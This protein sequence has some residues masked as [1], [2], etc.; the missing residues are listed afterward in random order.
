MGNAG[1]L[2][3]T[4]GMSLSGSGATLDL[5]TFNLTVP[6]LSGVSGTIVTS[7]GG[8]TLTTGGDNSNQTFG[9][10]IQSSLAVDKQGSGIWTLAGAN[11]YTGATTVS[12]GTLAVTGSLGGGGSLT[13]AL[14]ATLQGT[15]TITKACV[16][17]GD[18]SPGSSIGTI[19]LVGNQVFATGSTLNIELNPTMSDRVNVTGALTIQSGVTLNIIPDFGVYQA[20]LAYLIIDTT[21]GIT[22][23]FSTVT[24]SLPLFNIDNIV[25]TMD[26]ILIVLSGGFMPFADIITTG[27]ANQAAQAL[28]SLSA[29]SCCDISMVIATLR[30]IPTTHALKEALLQLQ[31]AL[32]TD[33][34]LA[35]EDNTHYVQNTI[36]HRLDDKTRSPCAST[37]SLTVWATLLGG[38]TSQHG[39]DSS[40]GFVANTPGVFVGI[41]SRLGQFS[42]VGC[43]V[44]YTYTSLNWRDIPRS[45][46]N[47][48]SRYAACYGK[49]ATSRL[50]VYSTLLGGYT[51][52]SAHRKMRFGDIVP[53]HTTAHSRHPGGEVGVHV[54]A[55][56]KALEKQ[57]TVLTPFATFDYL[58]LHE[59]AFRERGA[60]CLNLK[61]HSHNADLMAFE[62]GLDWTA[63][64]LSGCRQ[65][66][67]F[68]KLSAVQEIRFLGRHETASFQC[69]SSMFVRGQ[70]PQRTLGNVEAGFSGG[71]FSYDD[72]RV[73]FQARF[74]HDYRNLSGYLE[75]N[76]RF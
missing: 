16:I 74:G 15:G 35:Q 67:P 73:A 71:L 6:N 72:L 14:G 34:A 42:C 48:C 18:L 49:W 45:F 65:Y 8:V 32:Y 59:A 31:P 27:N 46:G 9:G 54:K 68:I 50:S 55:G 21:G 12:A 66:A 41:D 28:D 69:G 37:T 61:V 3:S 25:Q 70:N 29:A 4:S 10:S 26:D 62:A 76:Y 11:T 1:A 5:N 17:N 2:S 52:Y 53:V 22:G 51:L 60:Q 64:F 58:F 63:P 23:T 13:V 7:A 47:V 40:P 24:S 43:G 44:G 39:T 36:D 75:Y 33:F 30:F 19:T 38:H 56:Y 20:P 57:H